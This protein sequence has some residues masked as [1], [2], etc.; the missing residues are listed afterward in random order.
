MLALPD[1]LWA[2]ILGQAIVY[3]EEPIFSIGEKVAWF[4]VAVDDPVGMQVTQ[5]VNL[6]A[7]A[8]VWPEKEAK[9]DEEEKAEAKA[10]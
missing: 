9:P 4:Y 1:F 2:R 8:L 10:D 7:N 6:V 3:Q 5:L